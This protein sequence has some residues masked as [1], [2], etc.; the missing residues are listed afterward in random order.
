MGHPQT[1]EQGNAE[2]QTTYGKGERREMNT[3]SCLAYAVV[4]FCFFFQLTIGPTRL[5][6]PM[7][8]SV[9][10][11]QKSIHVLNVCVLAFPSVLLRQAT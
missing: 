7:Y 5:R 8:V 10:Y 4:F 3:L 9:L 6:L 1:S 2:I 11:R